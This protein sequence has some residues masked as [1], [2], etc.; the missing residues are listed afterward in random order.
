[1]THAAPAVE[2]LKF[3]DT[4]LSMIVMNTGLRW[5]PVAAAVGAGALPMW[6]GALVLFF[7]PLTIATAELTSRF[8]GEGGIYL[9]TGATFGPLPGFLCGW[10]YWFATLPYFAGILYFVAGLLMAALGLDPHNT[11]LFIGFSLVL[12]VAL[13]ALQFAGLAVSRWLPNVGTAGAWIIFLALAAIASVLLAE[14]Q[15]ATAFAATTYLPPLNSDTAV[16]LGTIIFAYSGNEAIAFMRDEIEGGVPTIIRVL[17]IVGVASSVFYALGTVAM[18]TIL[19]ASQMTRLGGFADVLHAVFAR[20]GQPGLEP[21]ALIFLA[22]SMLGGFTAWFSATARLLVS[23]GADRYLPAVITR[24]SPKTGAPVSAIFFQAALV[25]VM[26]VLGQGGASAAVAYD[27]L[28][29]M[30]ILTNTICYIFMFAAYFVSIGKAP[31]VDGWRPAGG[32]ATG[33]LIGTAGM[34]ATLAAIVCTLVPS[35]SDHAPLQT[36][37]KLIGSAAAMVVTGLALFW[38]GNRRAAAV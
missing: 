4:T 21:V 2:K 26:L 20:V 34:A 14:G 28:V 38:L 15:S 25:A 7:V 16:L 13:V 23:V 30:G 5:L 31:V 36:F 35:G 18:L 37:L 8:E 9:W 1:V 11:T 29:S 32:K 22:L 19:P 12:L 17:L 10:F 6:I 24:R 27:F 33:I 3:L